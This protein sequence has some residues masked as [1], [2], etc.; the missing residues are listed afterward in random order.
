[1][2]I[3][4]YIQFLA[5]HLVHLK[6]NP[7]ASIFYMFNLQLRGKKS[8]YE[9]NI[10]FSQPFFVFIFVFFVGFDSILS[11][12]MTYKLALNMKYNFPSY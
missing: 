8:R 10:D 6:C 7:L 4:N 2:R 1:M 3:D 11:K 5:A 12:D 9:V